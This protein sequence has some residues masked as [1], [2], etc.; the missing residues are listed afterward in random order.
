MVNKLEDARRWRAPEPLEDVRHFLN[1]WE[2]RTRTR[3]TRDHLP[4]LAAT[5]VVWRRRFTSVRLPKRG[6]LENL[7]QL[8][9][10]LRVAVEH[11][12]DIAWLNEQLRKERLTVAVARASDGTIT[13]QFVP[14]AEPTAAAEFLAIV[15]E[16]I[17]NG[18]WPR[19]KACPDC[20]LVFYDRSRNASK[21]WCQMAARDGGRACGSIAKVRSWRK[22]HA[23]G[24]G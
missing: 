15:V 22:R 24:R 9:D 5:A 13:T 3:D 11:G 4:G 1:S 6:E 2:Y 20:R 18:S 16:A 19:L 14:G 12:L 10:R 17:D 7:V 23:G 21:R 8:R